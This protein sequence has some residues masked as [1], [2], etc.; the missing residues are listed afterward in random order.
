MK[1]TM[2][3]HFDKWPMSS[4]Y[5]QPGSSRESDT[6]LLIYISQKL[7]TALVFYSF[8]SQQSWQNWTWHGKDKAG[9][10]HLKGVCAQWLMLMQMLMQQ[11]MSSFFQDCVCVCVWFFGGF[12]L[13]FF[14]AV[15]T[16]ILGWAW[17]CVKES[18]RVRLLL[19]KCQ[20]CWKWSRGKCVNGLVREL[21]LCQKQ[22]VRMRSRES[23]D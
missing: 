16:H 7:T 11:D 19:Q 14:S 10:E 6:F 23:A 20:N 8:I 9:D 13:L 12:V 15:L 18:S 3:N 2:F 1:N 17:R 4:L 21:P 22:L 5:I